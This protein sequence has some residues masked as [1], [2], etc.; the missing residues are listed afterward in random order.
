MKVYM[1]KVL[2]ALLFIGIKAEEVK[3]K[4]EL[5]LKTLKK[6]GL[7]FSYISPHFVIKKILKMHALYIIDYIWTPRIMPFSI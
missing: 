7:H 4:K 1:L 2:L 6:D 3:K 5:R